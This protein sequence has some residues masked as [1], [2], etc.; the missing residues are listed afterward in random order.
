MSR[1]QDE[2]VS[3]DVNLKEPLGLQ[4]GILYVT[5]QVRGGLGCVIQRSS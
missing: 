1:V 3:L 5:L 4:K 2:S